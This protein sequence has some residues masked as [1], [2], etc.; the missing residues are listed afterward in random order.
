MKKLPITVKRQHTIEDFIVDFYIAE[1]KLVIEID[2]SQHYLPDNKN[3]DE[4]RDSELGKWGITVVR[5]SNHDVNNNFQGVI[6]D[7]LKRVGLTYDV[8]KK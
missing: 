7:I 2:G 5:Y 1:K 4:K 6:F 3:A 8:L